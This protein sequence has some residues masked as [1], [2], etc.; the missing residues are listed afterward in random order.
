MVLKMD[1][2]VERVDEKIAKLGLKLEEQ[3]RKIDQLKESNAKLSLNLDEQNKKLDKH[4]GKIDQLKDSNEK[5]DLKM[6]E[7][8]KKVSD[9]FDEISARLVRLEEA[10]EIGIGMAENSTLDMTDLQKQVKLIFLQNRSESLNLKFVIF[11]CGR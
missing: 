2:F 7:Q 3:N 5:S 4:D 10:S 8:S 6:D 9:K 11:R 1:Q